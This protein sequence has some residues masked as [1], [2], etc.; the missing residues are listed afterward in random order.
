MEKAGTGEQVV[1]VDG[2]DNIVGAA[3]SHMN[4]STV[5][6]NAGARHAPLFGNTGPNA[7]SA[8]HMGSI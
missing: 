8:P 2:A 1:M 5:M 3:P 6:R 4:E 7:P